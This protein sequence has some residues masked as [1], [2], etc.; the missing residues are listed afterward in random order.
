MLTVLAQP[1]TIE[2]I[3]AQ[4]DENNYVTG[5]IIISLG[6]AI[7]NDL[8]GF[9]DFIAIELTGNECLMDINYE[10]IGFISGGIIL[11]V[12]GD[13]SSILEMEGEDEGV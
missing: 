1:L 6:D 4:K 13:V 12:T 5:N 10:E 2:E 8:E 11:K 3:K 9:L 7:D